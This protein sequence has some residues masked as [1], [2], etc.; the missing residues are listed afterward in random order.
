[1]SMLEKQ[2]LA[3][4]KRNSDGIVF[5]VLKPKWK[6]AADSLLKRNKIEKYRNENN[7]N[8]VYLRLVENS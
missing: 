5:D 6:K 8:L 2:L 3:S 4:I 1:M 7:N